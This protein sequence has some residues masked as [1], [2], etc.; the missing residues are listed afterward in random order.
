LVR[1]PYLDEPHVQT[2]PREVPVLESDEDRNVA[3]PLGRSDSDRRERPRRRPPAGRRN[4]RRH[5]HDAR[6]R[7][8][9]SVLTARRAKEGSYQRS[10]GRAFPR[11]PSRTHQDWICITLSTFT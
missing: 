5:Q 9:A 11:N 1:F 3:D 7:A 10:A 6:Y 2:P 4:E 8:P